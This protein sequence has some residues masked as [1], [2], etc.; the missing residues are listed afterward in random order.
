MRSDQLRAKKNSN[1]KKNYP[2]YTIKVI[3][4]YQKNNFPEWGRKTDV[5]PEPMEDFTF[6]GSVRLAI[7][8]DEGKWLHVIHN[9]PRPQTPALLVSTNKGLVKYAKANMNQFFYIQ[10]CLLDHYG[11]QRLD[12]DVNSTSTYG[13]KS[14]SINKAEPRT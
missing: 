14:L 13:L 9:D 2:L 11:E 7:D 12:E 3:F 1:P 5:I 8:E 10:L 4:I 6:K